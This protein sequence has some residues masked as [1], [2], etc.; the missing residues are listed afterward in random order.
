MNQ[1]SNFICTITYQYLSILDKSFCNI[2]VDNDNYNNAVNDVK[3]GSSC[4]VV[5]LKKRWRDVRRNE[6]FVTAIIISQEKET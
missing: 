5:N 2:K 1:L 4:W 6:C 3:R